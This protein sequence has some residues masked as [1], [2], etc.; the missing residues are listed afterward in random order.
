MSETPTQTP[1]QHLSAVA[2][3]LFH[4]L[5]DLPPEQRADFLNTRTAGNPALREALDALLAAHD[6][7]GE[8]MSG[9]TIAADASGQTATTDPEL[10]A[11]RIIGPYKLLQVIGEG[12]FGTVYLAEQEHPVRRR[13]ALKL[14]KAGMDTRAV[15]A[16]FEAE[17]QA[18]AMMD[19]PNIAKVFDAGATEMGRPYFV[20]ELVR[21]VPITEYCDQAQLTPQ[22]RLELFIPVCQAV[23]H[24]H[25]KGVIHRDLK[26]TNVLVTLHDGKPVPKVIDF[27]IAKATQQRL[28]EKTLFTEFRQMIGTPEYMSPE[29]AE[30]SGL[31]IDTRSDVYSLGV[32]LYELLTGATP[33]DAKELRSKAF[34]EMQRVIREVD[35]PRPSTKLSTLETLP[36]VAAKRRTEPRKLGALVRGELDWI[37]MRCLEKDRT[38]RYESP[39]ALAADV[40]RYLSDEPVSASPPSATYKAR[41]FVRRHKVALGVTAAMFVALLAGLIVALWGLRTARIERDNAI[42]ARKAEAEAREY[43]SQTDTFLTDMFTSISPEQARGR[44]VLVRDLLDQAAQRIDKSPPSHPLV[45]ASLRFTFG[46][47]YRALGLIDEAGHQ[48]QR[49]VELERAQRGPR[50]VATANALLELG[51]T[52]L[53]AGK[54]DEAERALREAVQT[55]GALKGADDSDTMGAQVNLSELLIK[56]G[57]IDEA[58][59]LL[60]PMFTRVRDK[61]GPSSPDAVMLAGALANLRDEQ[62][63]YDE[64]ETLLRSVLESLRKA[65]G[66]DHPDTLGAVTNLGNWM[67]TR[68]RSAEAVPMLTGAYRTSQ[69]V[70]GPDHPETLTVGNNLALCLQTLGRY[71]ESK[72]VYEDVIARRRRV[73][74]EDHPSTLL[75]RSNYGLVLQ[76]MQRYAEAE[77]TF[78]DVAE[79]LKRVV[80][81]DHRDTILAENNLAWLKMQTGDLA[82]AEMIYDDLLPRAIKA[83]GDEGPAATSLRMRLGHVL[84]LRE[85]W[86]DAEPLLAKAYEGAQKQ[87]IANSQAGYA[88]AYGMCLA[89]VNKPKEALPLLTL[90]DELMRKTPIADPTAKL[91][92][93]QS[94]LSA[95]EAL[96]D[97]AEAQRWRDRVA[98]L[99]R[100]SPATQGAAT[101][102]ASRPS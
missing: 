83:F 66:D 43:E 58:D 7:A 32:I 73:L 24:A 3:E 68:G 55:F 70:F 17:R 28:T 102:P 94:A 69:R 36:A 80:G 12:G 61:A 74:G 29:Q 77:T 54:H 79:R 1:Q 20:M 25:Q 46:R 8:F 71:D 56:R 101:N 15:I 39:S 93:A 100:A 10:R 41:K 59:K 50:H 42:A 67:R 84:M 2:K 48:L 63:R 78:R 81:P 53:M 89:H 4:D 51:I 72:A 23:Q 35:P 49:A 30:M 62:G 16:R 26:P 45:E 14:I 91:R 33:F 18:L 52:Y 97:K 99:G 21:G 31:D 27:G 38:R 47:A 37:V 5:L 92:I 22:Q 75:V 64:E 40:Q 86:A 90:A 34:A 65:Y 57:K 11:R 82:A 19:H 96:G 44:Q 9:P 6:L 98:E 13:V 85:K 88:S 87:G 60:T 76:G 95:A